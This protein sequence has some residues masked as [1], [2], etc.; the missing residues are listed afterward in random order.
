MSDISPIKDLSNLTVLHMSGNQISDISLVPYEQL[1]VANFWD[2]SINLDV[3]TSVSGE[4]LIIEIPSVYGF[5][6][7]ELNPY[8]YI[9]DSKYSVNGNKVTLKNISEDTY[10]D[11]VFS[12]DISSGEKR[13]YFG[14]T[15]KQ[16]VDVLK[17]NDISGHWAETT[18]KSFIGKKYINGYEDGTFRPDESITRA[19]FVKI[20]NKYFGLTNTSGKVFDDTN[21]H[22]AKDEI[23]IAVTNG[24]ANGMSDTEFAPDKPITREQAAKMIANYMKLDDSDHDKLNNYKDAN[25]VSKWAE[26][27]VEGILEKGYMNGYSDNTFRPTNNITRAEAVITL[28]RIK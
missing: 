19:E 1:T 12:D 16:A 7:K 3:V 11:V 9:S 21:K 10:L 6:G 2:Q 15:L 5:L 13:I 24:V 25:E 14:I 18:I 26:S 27:S 4:D 20:F 22:W 8:D 28:S 23:D 17:I